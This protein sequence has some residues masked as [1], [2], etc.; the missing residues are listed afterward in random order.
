MGTINS[1]DAVRMTLERRLGNQAAGYDLAS[2]AAI[3]QGLNRDFRRWVV[4]EAG[5]SPRDLAAVRLSIYSVN[6]GSIECLI[7]LAGKVS[8]ALKAV[9]WARQLGR[10][11][12]WIIENKKPPAQM[13]SKAASNTLSVVGDN[14]LILAKW[15]DRIYTPGEIEVVRD[16]L[17]NYARV[18]SQDTRHGVMLRFCK[19]DTRS[20]RGLEGIIEEVD[21]NPHPVLLARG[22]DRQQLLLSEAYPFRQLFEVSVDVKRNAEGVITAYKVLEVTASPAAPALVLPPSA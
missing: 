21:A 13:D 16:V 4:E 19:I 11:L 5:H 2:F 15:D 3:L 14:N 17:R 9:K 8:F 12:A 7:G 6:Q 20:S 1:D 10:N 22:I 18:S